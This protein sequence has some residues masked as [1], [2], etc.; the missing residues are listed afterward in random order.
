[1]TRERGEMRGSSRGRISPT[2]MFVVGILTAVSASFGQNLKPVRV[3]L[4]SIGS[5]QFPTGYHLSDSD[6]HFRHSGDKLFWLNSDSVAITF[7]KEFCCPSGGHSGIKHGAAVFDT[8]GNAVGTHDLVSL[9]DTPFLL[10]GG[11]GSFLLIYDSHIDALKSNFDKLGRITVSHFISPRL[12][13][14]GSQIAVSDR[15][16]LSVYGTADLISKATLTLPSGTEVADMN[17]HAVLLNAKSK[18]ACDIVVWQTGGGASWKVSFRPDEYG[19]CSTGYGE[20][21]LSDDAIVIRKGNPNTR[22][23]VS[24]N[25]HVE[26]ISEEGDLLGTASSGRFALQRFFPSA[27][28]DALDMDFGGKRAIT[29][30]DPSQKRLIFRKKFGGQTAAALA[31]DGHHLAVIEGNNLLIYPLP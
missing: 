12:S 22:E 6:P 19:G 11:V 20:G 18:S 25:G 8:S 24:R 28:A 5:P 17:D 7:F 4:R 13:T 31:P 2:V 21:L 23:I 14:D 15:G 9:P 27:F 30:Y 26:T 10:E 29:V 1:M 3:S 16:K